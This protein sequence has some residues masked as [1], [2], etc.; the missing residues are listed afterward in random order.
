MSTLQQRILEKAYAAVEKLGAVNATLVL[1]PSGYDEVTGVPTSRPAS[2]LRCSNI[3][4]FTK[5]LN[6]SL[7]GYVMVVNKGVM[8]APNTTHKLVLA[9]K[10]YKIERTVEHTM[11]EI[12]IAYELHIQGGQ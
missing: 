7:A 1:A 2:P 9:G 3:L 5:T 11:G 8:V 6:P 4:Q 12:V 10:E